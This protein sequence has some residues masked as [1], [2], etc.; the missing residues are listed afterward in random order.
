MLAPGALRWFAVAALA[1][2]IAPSGAVAQRAVAH[3]FGRINPGSDLWFPALFKLSDRIEGGQLGFLNN[4]LVFTLN[5]VRFSLPIPQAVIAYLAT[6]TARS[7]E[8]GGA[9]WS[10]HLPFSFNEQWFLSG[11]SWDPA[12]NLAG[13]INQTRSGGLLVTVGSASP[14]KPRRAR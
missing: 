10:S 8:A 4:H 7:I 1:I 11:M 12:T 14:R 3:P 2:P 6:D 9:R 13:A 5:A